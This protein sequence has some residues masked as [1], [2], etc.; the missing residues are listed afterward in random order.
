MAPS[1]RRRFLSAGSASM[2]ALGF[3]GTLQALQLRNAQATSGRSALAASPYGPV[4]PVRDEATGLPLL[5]LPAGFA[6]RSYGWTGDP[7]ADGRPCPGQHDGMAV[8]QSSGRGADR[9]LLLV[10][11][12]ERGPGASP[13]RARAVYDDAANRNDGLYAGGG[14][15]H[16]RF[17]GR[18][19]VGIEASLG[20]TLYNCAGGP[21]PWGSWLT[22]EET[23]ANLE[24]QGGRKHGYVFE[25]RA[26]AADTSGRPIV[27]MGRFSHEAV[28]IDPKTRHA[29]LTEDQRNKAG[30]YRFVPHD[31]SGRPGS[32]EAGGRLQMA[33]VV[34]RPNADLS[35]AATGDTHAIEWVDIADPDAD[36]VAIGLPGFGGPTPVSGPFAQGWARG[37]LR[38]ARGEGIWQRDGRLYLVDTATGVNADGAPG[39]GH[40]AVWEYELD[41]GR[42]S[43]LFVSL[44]AVAANHPDNITVSPRGGVLLC[45][46]GGGIDEAGLGRSERLLGLTAQG[47]SF[48]F[49]RNN[50]HL[51]AE[52]IAA[53]GKRVPPGD[54]R[55]TEFAGACFDP[56]GALLFVN[57]QSPGIT[58]AIWGPWSRGPF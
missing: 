53:A 14:T 16:L 25:V 29:Y 26:R 41:T 48:V 50:V 21:T 4:A 52:Q 17:K 30:F 55:A 51:G 54:Y 33:R 32:Y 23:L 1:S 38:M 10:R 31:A 7:M 58:F 39:H 3:A 9:E 19:W 2:A 28:A 49:A 40:G 8:V 36:P 20:G 44:D 34:G 12:H 24:P 42:L 57:V 45:E 22:C 11:N 6:Y 5:Q 13:I 56:A 47:E 37:G 27:D 46:D 18:D 43:A 35:V 15:T